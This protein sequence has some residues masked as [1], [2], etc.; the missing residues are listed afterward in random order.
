MDPKKKQKN[1][2][3]AIRFSQISGMMLFTTI[4][5]VLVILAF[6][7][8]QFSTS[9]TIKGRHLTEN[10]FRHFLSQQT[11]QAQRGNIYDSSGHLLAG[12]SSTYNL[13]AVVSKSYKDGSKPLYVVDKR[14]TAHV[15]AGIINL[16]ENDIYQR[17]NAK[18]GTFQVEF[19]SAGNN[20]TIDQHDK[21]VKADL[22][23]L[24]FTV[25]PARSYPNGVFASHIIGLTA[26]D[27]SKNGTPRLKGIM[28]LEKSLNRY[29]TGRQGFRVGQQTANG[30]PLT[31]FNHRTAKNGDNVYLT[32]NYNLQLQM[33]QLMSNIYDKTDPQAMTAI[34]ADAK[35]GAVLAASQRPS[36][37]SSTKSG[38]NKM[39]DDLLVQDPVEPGSTMKVFTLSAAI[40]SGH[41]N[42]EN[43]FQSGVLNIGSQKVFDFERN[44][45]V[46]SYR[47]GFARSSNVAFA[48]TEQNMGADTWRD[49]INRFQFLKAT[50]TMLPN[51]EGGSMV[52]TEPIEQANTAFGQGIRITPMQIVQALTA[53]AN[54]GRMIRPYIVEKIKDPTSKKNVYQ[55]RP[56]ISAPVVS[57]KTAAQVRKDMID[58]VNLPDGTART[59]SL[60]K[61]G[62]QIAAKTGTAQ[63]AVDGKY[64]NNYSSSTH[65]VEALVPADNPRFIFYMYIRQ[66]RSFIGG[67][68]DSTI[69]TLFHPLIISAL[70]NV[71]SQPAA[72]D[73]A[74]KIPDFYGKS[75]TQAQQLAEDNGLQMIFVG[76]RRA[77]VSFQSIGAG[78]L[79]IVDQ[80]IFLKSDDSIDMPDMKGWTLSDVSSFAKIAGLSLTY[81]GA[82]TVYKQSIPVDTSLEKGNNLEVYLE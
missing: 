43:V 17:L 3:E 54:N 73:S 69:N 34:L 67:F 47:E 61:Q 2:K 32:L 52:F 14:K 40:D 8:V 20:L 59:Y 42:P 74:K 48:K 11:T 12:N 55:N 28:G 23:G 7:F 21:I 72:S 24:N 50:N 30:V 27:N 71:K 66:P 82:G 60:A 75:Y 13:Y 64:T 44:M 65:S 77:K 79:V 33:E 76:S 57:P 53:V 5:I 41:W 16:P 10:D 29:L 37:N 31:T 62:Y 22:P 9:K 68:A 4:L 70:N 58:V 36:F 49:Y 1:K 6:H 78:S 63:I 45:G 35:T 25:N 46:I 56:V 19:G 18:K 38:L 81:H 39:W 26:N 51:E 15:L 80:K